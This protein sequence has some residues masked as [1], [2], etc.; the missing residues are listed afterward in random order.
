MIYI[1][2]LTNMEYLSL[3]EIRRKF[4]DFF[5]KENHLEIESF[6]LIPSESEKSLLLINSGMAPLKPY[7]SGVKT[8]P[9]KRVTTSQKCIRTADIELIGKTKRHASFFEM[10]G[11]FSF[12]DYFKKESIDFGYRFIKDELKMPM[13]KIWVSVYEEDN[14]SYDIWVNQIKFPKDR[15]VKLGKSDNFWEIGLGPCGPCSE[16]YF[17]RGEKY[18]CGKPDCKPGCDC[19]RY[20]EFWNHVFTE[21]N[22]NEDGTYSP[23][24]NKNI[25]TGMGLERLATIIQGVDSIY[26]IDSNKMLLDEIVKES[27]IKYENGNEKNSISARIIV[28]HIKAATFL[29]GDGLVPN[30]TERE[31]VLRKLIRRMLSHQIKLNIREGFSEVLVKKVI[32][33]Y[34][35]EY[36]TLKDNEKFI[37]ET[38]NKEELKFRKTIKAGFEIIEKEIEKCIKNK[39]KKV[40]ADF[41]FK[42]YDTYGFPFDLTTELLLEKGLNV[43]EDEFNK[44]LEEQ[45]SRSKNALKN[46]DGLGWE[47]S[48]DLSELKKTT[49]V[50]YEELET[51]AELQKIFDSN[52]NEIKETFEDGEYYL[53]FDKTPF[54]ATGGGQVADTGMLI[55]GEQKIK[56]LDV[57]KNNEIYIHFV[58]IENIDKTTLKIG[59]KVMLVVSKYLRNKTSNN[60]TAVHLLHLALNEVLGSGIE[61]KGSFVS[62]NVGRLDFNYDKKI[63]L[64]DLES[65]ENLV[66]AWISERYEVYSEEMSLNEAKEK[67]AVALFDEKYGD[68]VRVISI[69]RNDSKAL[70]IELCG[71]THTKNIGFLGGFNIISESSQ[72]TGIRRIEAITGDAITK[73]FRESLNLENDLALMFSAKREEILLKVMNMVAQN[74]ELSKKANRQM[75]DVYS[76]VSLRDDDVEKVGEINL[77]VKKVDL[78]LDEAKG[79]LD[80]LSKNEKTV[81]VL[82]IENKGKLSLLIGVS[83]DLIENGLGANKIVKELVKNEV[84]K[85]GGK[86]NMSQIGLNNNLAKK[87]VD[88]IKNVISNNS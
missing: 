84:G 44:K 64:E 20:I 42:L 47:K 57:Q 37:I 46:K 21:F 85:G 23:L 52:Y 30:N 10:L 27:K 36:K 88:I 43:S 29:I 41:T 63:T 61:Q 40:D 35:G 66:N 6:S 81:S 48:F 38:L 50:G 79:L 59:D 1:I 82:E 11:S 9:S 55:L 3:T 77:Y 18:S 24:K 2:K 72:G 17:D 12:G 87:A 7:F 75:K 69:M 13:D 39:I 58:K 76:N 83:K 4:K 86:E 80:N 49:F 65:I 19:E 74:K 73:E 33:Y 60:H 53:V 14:E 5:V 25:D 22:K 70:S 28:D 8:P 62:S 67:G 15:I 78:S 54:Y 56:V 71:G 68:T 34:Q 31:Y 32:E 16:I 51:K 26:E 45:R